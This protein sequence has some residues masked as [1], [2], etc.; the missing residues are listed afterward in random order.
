MVVVASDR[1]AAMAGFGSVQISE[2]TNGETLDVMVE[3]P[4]KENHPLSHVGAFYVR[5]SPGDAPQASRRRLF[6]RS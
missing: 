6:K 2:V 1:E 5:S 3:P 4:G